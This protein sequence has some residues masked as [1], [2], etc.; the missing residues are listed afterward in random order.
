MFKFLFTFCH[1]PAI[2]VTEDGN[3]RIASPGQIIFQAA[4]GGV[5]VQDGDGKSVGLPA[6]PKGDKVSTT[7][8]SCEYRAVFVAP[9][10]AMIRG[11]HTCGEK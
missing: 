3:V 2:D 5:L 8:R 11:E 9:Y 1:S 4:K 6:G 7:S 10:I